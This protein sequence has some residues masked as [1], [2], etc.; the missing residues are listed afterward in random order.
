[1]LRKLFAI[2]WI[3]LIASACSSSRMSAVKNS[4][5]MVNG[6]EMR[7]SVKESV[8][9]AVHDTI[10]EV[11]TVTVDRNEIG[12]TVRVSTVM[13][14]VRGRGR[15]IIATYRTKT[16]VVRDTVFIE[17]RDSIEIRSRP[18]DGSEKSSGFVTSLKWI[19]AIVIA[20]IA[21][22]IVVWVRGRP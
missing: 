5:F 17:K 15:Y 1:M 22:M 16:E 13:D 7:D 8:M 11:T 2:V 12:D 6:Y 3:V 20:L 10:V 19:F 21:L 4:R 9:V 14:R 18:I